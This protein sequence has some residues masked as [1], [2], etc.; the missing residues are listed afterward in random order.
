LWSHKQRRG[1]PATGRW[2]QHLWNHSTRRFVE[3]RCLAPGTL[4]ST[5]EFEKRKDTGAVTSP[6]KLRGS[7]RTQ[8]TTRAPQKKLRSSA[9][10]RDGARIVS[11][12]TAREQAG[13]NRK[14]LLC[15]GL[16]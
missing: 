3:L 9:V 5:E 16:V 11:V 1:E 13:L 12:K 2:L 15:L 14:E 10:N 6:G 7:G 4:H 8:R